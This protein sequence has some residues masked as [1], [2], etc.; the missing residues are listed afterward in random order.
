[1]QICAWCHRAFEAPR[2]ELNRGRGRFCSL[3][4]AASRNNSLRTHHKITKLCQ[5]CGQ[6][7]Q[8]K[9]CREAASRYCSR[10]CLNSSKIRDGS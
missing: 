10:S 9:A 2:K 4:R 3:S 6:S 8:V 1:M 7:Y 5:I